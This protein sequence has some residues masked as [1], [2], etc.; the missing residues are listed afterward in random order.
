MAGIEGINKRRKEEYQGSNSGLELFL[1]DGHQA[2]VG[3]VPSGAEDDLRLGDFYRHSIEISNSDTSKSWKYL[4]CPK[5]FD[6]DAE[7]VVCKEK[8]RA[9]HR[10][11]FWAYVYYIRSESKEGDDWEEEKSSGGATRFRREVNDFRVFSQ[12]FGQKDYIWGQLVDIYTENGT[13]NKYVV[14]I[15]RTGSAMKDTNYA[16]Q[17]MLNNEVKLTADMKKRIKDLPSIADFYTQQQEQQAKPVEESKTVS[18]FDDGDDDNE[19]GNTLDKEKMEDL[20]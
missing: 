17:A 20:F 10:F 1:K 19:S 9:Q 12:G 7:C 3:I 6:A 5:T 15:K 4:I 14:R 2:Y 16:I 8:N 13:L 11:G 18:L